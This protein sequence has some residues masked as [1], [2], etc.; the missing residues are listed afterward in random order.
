MTAQV[1]SAALAD[2][3]FTSL[4]LIPQPGAG[5][6]AAGKVIAVTGCY[7]NQVPFATF[8]AACASSQFCLRPRVDQAVC[9]VASAA[10]CMVCGVDVCATWAPGVRHAARARAGRLCGARRRGQLRCCAVAERP[11]RHRVLGLLAQDLEVFEALMLSGT[12]SRH[13][14]LTWNPYGRGTSPLLL[15]E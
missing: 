5:L 6:A 8:C 4:A 10:S 9:M 2:V 11:A 1:R 14:V 15:G 12:S 7:D 3:P 13:A